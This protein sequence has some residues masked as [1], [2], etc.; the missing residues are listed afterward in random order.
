MSDF[1]N[2]LRKT[3]V[4]KS[5][6]TNKEGY[7][8][9]EKCVS[10]VVNKTVNET[11]KKIKETIRHSGYEQIG[12][13]KVICGYISLDSAEY[14]IV[15]TDG[16]NKDTPIG[17]GLAD[18]SIE[19]K[20]RFSPEMSNDDMEKYYG[21]ECYAGSW[22]SGDYHDR[23]LKCILLKIIRQNTFFSSYYSYHLTSTAEDIIKKINEMAI[24]DGI[25]ISFD[26]ITLLTTGDFFDSERTRIPNGGRYK[27]PKNWAPP[28][29]CIMLKYYVKF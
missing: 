25:S 18:V 16:K 8:A 22:H 10:A 11:Y 6:I 21:V 15:F 5:N 14:K 17:G 12:K 3:A 7:S 19:C 27:P 1:K 28:N 23:A 4:P 13:E 20:G 26:H 29:G 24:K 2:E 9:F